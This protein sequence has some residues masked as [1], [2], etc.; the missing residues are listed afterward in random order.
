[1]AI[2]SKVPAARVM[3]TDVSV[4]M[5]RICGDR[6]AAMDGLLAQ[7]LSFATYGGTEA[8]FAPDAFDTCYGT[9][10]VH[11]IIDVPRLLAQIHGLLKPNGRAFFMEPNLRFH[12]ALTA[13]LADILADWIRTGAVPEPQIS[14]MLNWIA[15]V[16]CNVV[17]SGDVE[18]LAQ[19][20]D[21]HLFVAE[22]FTAMAEAAGFASAEALPCGPDPTGLRTIETYLSQCG[23]TPETFRLLRAAWPQAQGRHFPA[24]SLR[25]S[26]PSYLFW[27]VKGPRNR[28]VRRSAAVERPPEPQQARAEAP[29]HLWL[30]LSVGHDSGGPAIM[31]DGW[32]ASVNPV[33]SVQLTIGRTRVRLPVWLPRPDV[34]NAVN[35]GNAY[36]ALH[37]LCSGI[38]GSFPIAPD[39]A[40][41]SPV[42]ARVDIVAPGDAVVPVGTLA[43]R[44]DG[45]PEVIDFRGACPAA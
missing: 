43:L 30:Q 44:P 32:C 35:G 34:H 2:L 16:H 13:T 36:P 38:R 10:V 5:L 24:L 8:C 27:L 40:P 37:A 3:L 17:N 11:H 7:D 1:M 21:K 15:E 18:V 39:Q 22:E 20:E 23:V 12:H 42:V 9:A 33:K 25:D 29:F 28:A 14:P 6:L 19:R 4:K 41:A 26:A 31:A 45:G